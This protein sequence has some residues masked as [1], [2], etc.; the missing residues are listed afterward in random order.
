MSNV[1]ASSN[2]A[3]SVRLFQVGGINVYV[4]WSWLI[5]AYIEL[6]FRTNYYQSTFWN[7]IEYL[8][9]FGIVL[10]HEFGHAL[11]CRQVG[12]EANQIVLWP[13]GGI[14]FV[15]PPQRPGPVLWSIA[16]GPLVNVVLVPITV[17][18]MLWSEQAGAGVDSDMDRYLFELFRIN[19]GLLIFN[20]LPIYPLD[21]G[22]ILQALLWFVIG[23][24]N[25][26]RVASV[27]GILGAAGFVMLAIAWRNVWIGILAAFM[28]LRS[29]AGIQQA[30]MLAKLLTLPRRPEARCPSCGANPPIGEV[31]TC[32]QCGRAF[33][34]FA[35]QATCP[36]CGGRFERTACVDCQQS[37]PLA[38]WHE[39]GY[40][41][42]IET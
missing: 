15:N 27:I 32:G 35:Q 37:H 39:A 21:G 33:D 14:A 13:L 16:A 3:G 29:V 1:A 30:G 28:G 12:G 18:L 22:Q 31:W 26:L 17:A 19:L 7:V 8:S 38:A 11:A 36:G 2:L 34:T 41:R 24:A 6:Q 9:L 20:M 40:D 10:L 25:S 23:R 42:E 4:H 5:V